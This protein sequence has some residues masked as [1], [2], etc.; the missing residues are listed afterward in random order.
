V[1][2]AISVLLSIPENCPRRSRRSCRGCWNA[3]KIITKDLRKALFFLL[4]LFCGNES[5][6]LPG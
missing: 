5:L 4:A 3:V 1:K 2:T 6:L